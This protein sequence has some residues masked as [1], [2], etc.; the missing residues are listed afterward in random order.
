MKINIKALYQT[1]GYRVEKINTDGERAQVELLWDDRFK[2]KCS[3]CGHPMRIN[4]KVRQS[5]TDLPLASA[6]YVGL[7]Y[8]AVQGY[9]RRCAVYETIRPLEIVRTASGHAAADAPGESVV[10]LVAVAAHL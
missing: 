8:E 7:L 9:C 4:R 5:A 1:E 2:P 3:R 10:P 6:G